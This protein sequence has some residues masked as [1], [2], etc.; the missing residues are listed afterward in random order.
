MPYDGMQLGRYH[1]LRM[2]G[3]GGMGEVYLADD[4]RIN[5]QV[6]IKVI[7]NETSSYPNSDGA[8]RNAQLFER[9]MKMISKLDHPHI[10][11]LFDYGE[12]VINGAKITYMVMPYRPEG[13]LATWLAQR[14]TADLLPPQDVAYFIAQAASALQ[15]AHNHQ[16]IHQDVKPSNFLMRDR[17]EQPQRPDLLLA[18][19]G[20]ARF[21]T[22]NSNTSQTIR[23]TPAYM[24][25]EQWE[26]HPTYASDQYALAVMTYELLTGK[27][28]F[29]GNASQMMYK[30]LMT[31][32]EPPTMVLPTLPVEVDAVILRALS[33]K[34]EERYPNINAYATA[35]QQALHG[36][37]PLNT[38]ATGP[39]Y[40]VTRPIGQEIPVQL[41]ITYAEAQHGTQRTLKI[42]GQDVI[43]KIPAGARTGRVI[44]IDDWD[45]TLGPHD[46]VNP[47]MITLAVQNTTSIPTIA[48]G[49]DAIA[50]SNPPTP[51]PPADSQPT[52]ISHPDLPGLPPARGQRTSGS[53]Y[54]G[55]PP[56]PDPYSPI[57]GARPTPANI[58][59]Q[60]SVDP[61]QP[62][63]PYESVAQ[64]YGITPQAAPQQPPYGAQYDRYGQYYNQPPAAP[65]RRGPSTPV[66]LLLI[67]LVL[68]LIVG[69]GGAIYY[70]TTT[71]RN[72]TDNANGTATAQALASSNSQTQTAAAQGNNGA[73]AT[74][75][76]NAT[77]TAGAN[78]TATATTTTGVGNQNATATAGAV[79][80][81]TAT[82]A[83]A[84]AT[85]AAQPTPTPTAQPTPTPVP[86]TI[87]VD[88]TTVSASA[89]AS[90][91]D[92]TYGAN[93]GGSTSPGWTCQVTLTNKGGTELDWTSS[94]TSSA[95]GGPT[96]YSASTYYY[97]MI[98]SAGSVY[99]SPVSGKIAAQ[100]TAKVDL[101][102]LDTNNNGSCPST[103]FTF[104]FSG[105]NNAVQVQWTCK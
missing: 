46:P 15:Y 73:T 90:S 52:V 50:R 21:S 91:T 61:A 105:Q 37:T 88:K 76:A 41:A 71:N 29:E 7:R 72:N 24:A 38:G 60:S 93:A 55:I 17:Q 47:L 39:T 97:N 30:H 4:T 45:P 53:S 11:P 95:S 82:A 31:Q 43:I 1:L 16:I 2:L 70:F 5:R 63:L 32:P 67:L 6:A 96:A 83:A 14:P 89:N 27:S 68:L 28:P 92:C 103:P 104:T 54:A 10:L 98:P 42:R 94:S 102:V 19:F 20:V 59:G 77:G 65:E 34:P 12:D 78:A 85:A 49:S 81:A 51:Y 87:A 86:A 64:P 56:L 18:D 23:G 13:S 66:I 44:R 48:A 25:P 69:S 58:Y 75:G 22:A 84:T 3:S 80:N 74:A 100:D 9:E 40:P 99:T 57:S 79:A 101:V 62:T 33:K 36:S 26:G 35:L 8:T